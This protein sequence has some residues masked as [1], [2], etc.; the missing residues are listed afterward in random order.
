MSRIL[1]VDDNEN[2]RLL[3]RRALEDSDA[4]IFEATCA[5]QA[6]ASVAIRAPE[7]VLLDAD[8]SGLDGFETLRW[9]KRLTQHELLPVVLL[10]RLDDPA[11]RLRSLEM[12]ADVLLT[13]PP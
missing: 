13:K 4:A 6:L 2:D 9:I 12:G 8:S 11:L 10:T 5:A 7:L 3:L 1:I